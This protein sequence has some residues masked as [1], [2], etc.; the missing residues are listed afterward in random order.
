MNR[1]SPDPVQVGAFASVLCDVAIVGVEQEKCACDAD[2]DHAAAR[3]EHHL[4]LSEAICRMAARVC[5][6]E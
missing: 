2:G 3:D 4:C 5:Q 1:K 6:P